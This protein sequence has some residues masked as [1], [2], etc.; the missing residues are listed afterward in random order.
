M[1]TRYTPSVDNQ[2]PS[3]NPLLRQVDTVNAMQTTNFKLSFSRMPNVTFWCTS[4]NIPSVSV[5]EVT[6]PTRVM[7]IHVPGSSIQ[8]D[9]LRL[10]FIVDENFVNWREI[11]N[12][13]RTI[14]PFED[15]NSIL[16]NEQEYYSEA[17]IH[18]L[19]NA[20]NPNIKFTF[21]NAFPISLDGFDLNSALNEPE[22]V[23]I[24]ATFIYDT[25]DVERVT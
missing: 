24:N 19:S 25:F 10:T 17:T 5:G 9:Q 3:V 13:M 6:V 7:P 1:A 4:V 14:V 20:K 15:M 11:Y 23:T 21:K 22:P 2:I 12:W 18:C 8:L 16:Q